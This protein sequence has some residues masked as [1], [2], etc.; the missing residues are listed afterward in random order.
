VGGIYGSAWV[1]GVVITMILLSKLL[2]G[3]IV[4]REERDLEARFGDRYREYA[5]NVPRW[6]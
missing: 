1:S 6:I 2:I 5:R 3:Q 4:R